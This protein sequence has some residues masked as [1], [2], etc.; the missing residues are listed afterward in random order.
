MWYRDLLA[1]ACQAGSSH[2]I[3]QDRLTDLLRQ[4][5]DI[6]ATLILERLEALSLLHRQLRANLNSELALNKFSL[7]WRQVAKTATI[8]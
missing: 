3:N 2:L 4:Q 7:Q 8:G 6:P 5:Q 1:L